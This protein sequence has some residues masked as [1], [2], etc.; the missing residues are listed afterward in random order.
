MIFDYSSNFSESACTPVLCTRVPEYFISC[1]TD[2]VEILSGD[3]GF[4][5]ICCIVFSPFLGG[6]Q[7]KLKCTLKRLWLVYS[8]VEFEDGVKSNLRNRLVASIEQEATASPYKG[9]CIKCLNFF[10][11]TCPD[12]SL[13]N[14]CNTNLRSIFRFD[15]FCNFFHELKMGGNIIFNVFLLFYSTDKSNEGYI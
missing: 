10:Y 11:R 13:P 15:N 14:F 7:P 8:V 5:H 1:K 9:T 3:I 12:K 6:I 2:A 4:R